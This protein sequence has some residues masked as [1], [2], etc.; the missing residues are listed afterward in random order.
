MGEIFARERPSNSLAFSGERMTSAAAGQIEIEHF[1][2]YFLARQLCRGKDVLDVASGEGYGAAL[3]SQVARSVVGVELSLDAVAHASAAYGRRNVAFLAADARAMPLA[4]ASIDVVVSFE[5][6]EHFWEQETFLTEVKRVLRPGGMAIISSPDRD[7]YSPL[8]RD[9]NPFHVKELTRSEFSTLVSGFFGHQAILLQRPLIGSALI[10]ETD[11]TSYPPD[12]I[13]FE[14][15][16]EDR[17]EVSAGLPR[18]L[19]IV[20]IASDNPIC[21]VFSSLYIETSHIDLLA[22]Q[23]V[24]AQHA[25]A[26]AVAG[27]KRADDAL[28]RQEAAAHNAEKAQAELN[29]ELRQVRADSDA[30]RAMLEARAVAADAERERVL[31]ST[32]WRLTGPARRIAVCIPVGL[33]FHLR[34]GAKLLYWILTPHRTRQRFTFIKARHSRASMEPTPREFT[35]STAPPPSMECAPQEL[36]ASTARPPLMECTPQ[37]LTAS[38]AAPPARFNSTIAATAQN[39]LLG[40]YTKRPLKR[41]A[42]GVVTYNNPVEDL[43]RL[44][45]T[46][47]AALSRADAAPGSG[48]LMLDNGVPTSSTV[49]GKVPVRLLPPVGNIGFGPGQNRIM[50]IAF[51]EGADI[52]IAANPDGAFHPNAVSALLHMMQAHRD[53]ILMEATQFPEEHPKEYDPFTF[54]TPWASGACLAV[55]RGMYEEIGGFDENFFLYCEDVDLSWR[56]RAAGFRVKICPR[57]FFLHSVTNRLPSIST[58]CHYLTSGVILARKWR[59]A[60]FEAALLQELEELELSPPDCWPPAVPEEWADIPDFSHLFSFA[61]ARW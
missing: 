40:L 36:T 37:E 53:E 31:H 38:T 2:R 44:L 14:R 52:Y 32:S 8:D 35:A 41:V 1:H 29:A 61:P 21:E 15:R 45:S 16:G 39:R 18:A 49:I 59:C 25:L 51:A 46:A 23:V 24:E 54:E 11:T 26:E 22:A 4:D 30:A 19:Y 28:V 5:T 43:C 57:A 50:S 42:I 47:T 58:R 60:P 55:P 6:I 13:T 7:V 20:S 33:R 48:I 10:A 27:R 56:A 9:A 3:L 12:F 17:F 34:R